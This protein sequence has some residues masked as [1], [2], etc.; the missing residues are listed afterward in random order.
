MRVDVEILRLISAFGIIWYHSGVA[1]GRDIGYAGLICFLTLAGYFTAISNKSHTVESRVKRLLVPCVIWSFVY[2]G[3]SLG[4]GLDV[5][6]EHYSLISKILA[7]PSI[8]LWFLPF[9]FICLV[10]TDF[11]KRRISESTLGWTAGLLAIALIVFAP[12]WRDLEFIEPLQ[13]YL[14]GLP[15]LLIGVFLGCSSGVHTILRSSLL[16]AFW[17]YIVHITIIGADNVGITYFVGFTPCLILLSK[18]SMIRFRLDISILSST[19][20]GIYLCHPLVLTVFWYLGV[21][22]AILPALA[23]SLSIIAVMLGRAFL[24]RSVVK[25]TL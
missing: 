1:Q 18:S 17:G 3:L 8:H 5:F 14:H 22:G 16:L 15:A 12:A 7:T 23:F 2:V 24:P 25:Y 11:F 19:A 20:F 4:R 10:V 21:S 9:L 13:Q 6:P